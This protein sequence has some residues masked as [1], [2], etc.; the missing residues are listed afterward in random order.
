MPNWAGSNWYF[1]RYLDPHNSK[2]LAGKKLMDYWMPVDVYEGGYEHTTLHLLYSRFIYK[3]LFDIGVVPN[4]EPYAARRAHGILLGSDNRKMSKSFG[5]VVDPTEVAKKYGA[6]TLRLYEMFIGPFDQQVS[7]NDRSL[8]GCRR[9]LDRVWRLAGGKL[10]KSTA[11]ALRD[12]L[13]KTVQKVSKDLEDFKFNTAVAAMMELVN[14][15]KKAAIDKGDW[16]TFVKVL[17]PFAPHLA[18]ELWFQR[19]QTASVHQ[20]SWPVMTRGVVGQE[21]KLI[22]IA[23]NGKPRGTVLLSTSGG[24]VPDQARI[25]Q[26]AQTQEKVARFLERKKILKTIYVPGKILNFVV[27]PL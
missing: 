24:E 6:D 7:W 1:L 18:E 11:P 25:V 13:V 22:V 17:A 19:G 8:I 23:V 3:F 9:F 15:W 12:K 14:A 21:D 26:M 2:E 4:E 20:Q 16:E 5:N 27:N 10:A